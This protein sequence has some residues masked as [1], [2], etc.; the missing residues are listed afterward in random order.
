MLNVKTT[1]KFLSFLIKNIEHLNPK[2]SLNHGQVRSTSKKK[3]KIKT[4]IIN[5]DFHMKILKY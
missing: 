5:S 3:K 4:I 2:K 1:T